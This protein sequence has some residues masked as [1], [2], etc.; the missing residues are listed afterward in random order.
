MWWLPERRFT[1]DLVV[2]LLLVALTAYVVMETNNTYQVI[3]VRSRMM[4]SVW[5][6][7]SASVIPFHYFSPVLLATFCLAV[8]IYLLFRTYQQPQPVVD[9]F[10][11]F[12]LL[13]L[14]SIVLPQMALFAPF[15]LWY[16]IVFMRA[17]SLRSFFAGL[18]GLVLPF[19]FWAAWQIWIGDLS[20]LLAWWR[21]LLSTVDEGLVPLVQ[22]G[23]W[24]AVWDKVSAWQ[25]DFYLSNATF[26]VLFFLT[27]WT[28]VYYL[29][30][31]F[32][33]KIRTRM[34]MYVYLMQSWLIIILS[35][36][37]F[38][39]TAFTPL[40]MFSVTPL[41]AHYFTLRNTWVALIV[42]LLTVAV[43]III[44][45]NPATMME[46]FLYLCRTFQ[47]N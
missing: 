27:F 24:Q 23:G 13:A 8:S 26:L 47:E 2:G 25:S 5:L 18:L 6:F 41:L 34:M 3:R 32:D 20:P 42:F 29:E 9:T 31:S 43:F 11:S 15:F 14:G 39:F 21:D 10:H 37:T 40:L 35:V 1:P 30:S 38:Q 16:F 19:W 46:Y 17:L 45:V 12:L 7:L 4:S 22:T 36:V 44:F 33:D 28:S